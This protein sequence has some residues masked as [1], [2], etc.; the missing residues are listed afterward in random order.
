VD[1]AAFRDHWNHTESSFE[2]FQ[3]WMQHPNLRPELWFLAEDEATGEVVGLGLNEIKPDRIARNGRQEG[4]VDTV[5][6]LRAYRRRGVGTALLAQSLQALRK[7]GMD[8]ADLDADAEN[9]TGAMRIYKRLGFR[10]RK[11]TVT[12]QRVMRE[13]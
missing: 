2:E 7:A 6:V 13:A 5:A 8:A 11:T 4:Y 12:Y 3:H 1:N 9:L 10:V